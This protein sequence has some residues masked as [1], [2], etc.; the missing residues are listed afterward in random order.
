[1]GPWRRKGKSQRSF[2]HIFLCENLQCTANHWGLQLFPS[3][4]FWELACFVCWSWTDTIHLQNG[5]DYI[6]TT[7]SHQS[8]QCLFNFPETNPIKCEFTLSLRDLVVISHWFATD[9]PGQFSL[10]CFCSHQHK[11]P[12]SMF[13][14]MLLDSSHMYKLFIC[15]SMHMG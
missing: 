7:S 10:Y 9:L 11:W 15:K 5:T 3:Y 4:Q 8:S 1:M 12:K 13:I 2:V 6:W 14:H